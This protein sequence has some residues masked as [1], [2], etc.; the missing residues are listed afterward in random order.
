MKSKI[1]ARLIHILG[2]Y[3]Q[4]EYDKLRFAPTPLIKEET[5]YPVT[6]TEHFTLHKT[7]WDNFTEKHL[8]QSEIRKDLVK[9]LVPALT[10]L[11]RCTGPTLVD[12][13]T[14]GFAVSITVI[15]PPD[16]AEGECLSE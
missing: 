2:G 11:V 16:Y 9:Y 8:L 6:V 13:E 12:P 3:T 14:Y 10:K 1:K 7:L 5:V 4:Q 15:P